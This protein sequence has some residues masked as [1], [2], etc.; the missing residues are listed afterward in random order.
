MHSMAHL[1]ASTPQVSLRPEGV[2]GV[3]PATSAS[4]A[5]RVLYTHTLHVKEGRH[6]SLANMVTREKGVSGGAHLFAPI[7]K[8][9][10][11]IFFFYSP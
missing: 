9:K 11:F 10:I 5:P 6:T 1:S 3:I 7:K 8:K 2:G 4:I